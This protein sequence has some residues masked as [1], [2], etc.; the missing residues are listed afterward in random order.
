MFPCSNNLEEILRQILIQQSACIAHEIN[1]RAY[2][3][4][5]VPFESF[6]DLRQIRDKL[7]PSGE[8]QETQKK[9]P[10]GKPY[11]FFYLTA[12]ESKEVNQLIEMK[13][14]LL[15][16]YS[17]HTMEIGH[18]G[19]DL[20]ACA[21]GRLGFTEIEVRKRIGKKDIDV[22]C[23]DPSGAFHWAIEVKNRRQEIDKHDIDDALFKAELASDTLNVE[24]VKAAMVSSSIYNRIPQNPDI[25]IITTGRLYVPNRKLFFVYQKSLGSW[26]MVHQNC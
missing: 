4:C 24:C 17:E 20:V 7:I 15:L 19:E 6:R 1:D 14:K 9:S 16:D 3:N 11:K 21:V 22:W 25:P 12:I 5:G 26:F 18:F 23:R 8:I 10:Y 13:H 2:Y